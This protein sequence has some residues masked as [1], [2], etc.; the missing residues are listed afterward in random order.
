LLL[1]QQHA[2][3]N[4]GQPFISIPTMESA[5]S[6]F[7][8]FAIPQAQ[9]DSG[10]FHASLG[11]PTPLPRQWSLIPAY[12]ESCTRLLLISPIAVLSAA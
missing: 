8:L 10:H 4:L 11:L 9:K 6:A 2:E 5:V 12:G 7:V 1:L 3:S